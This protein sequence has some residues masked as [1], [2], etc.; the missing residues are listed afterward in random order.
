MD[1]NV[2]RRERRRER[3]LVVVGTL[4]E[5]IP[6]LGN[7]VRS[8]EVFGVEELIIGNA[9]I[10][11]NSEFKKITVTAEKWL[12]MLQISEPDLV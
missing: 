8:C 4:I 12:P 7:L 2:Y 1:S 11:N 5:K 6:N 9:D 10:V 3:G